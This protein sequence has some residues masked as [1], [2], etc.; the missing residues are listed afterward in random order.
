MNPMNKAW[1]VLKDDPV[2]PNDPKYW[3]GMELGGAGQR[4]ETPNPVDDQRQEEAEQQYQPPSMLDIVASSEDR[5]Q[6]VSH[7]QALDNRG[8]SNSKQR[9]LVNLMLN[10]GHSPGSAMKKIQEL[11]GVPDQTA[12]RYDIETDR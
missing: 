8:H 2:D 1:L 9:Y 3:E 10:H 4:E 6:L 11:E 5:D 7:I 12:W